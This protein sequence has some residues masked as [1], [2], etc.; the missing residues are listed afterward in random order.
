MVRRG[1]VS[2]SN[3]HGTTSQPLSWAVWQLGE[4]C[5]H[6]LPTR[7]AVLP[8]LGTTSGMTRPARTPSGGNQDL[9][10]L[11]TGAERRE[12]KLTRQQPP[13]VSS[14]SGSTGGGV[15]GVLL[16]GGTGW[17]VCRCPQA[18]RLWAPR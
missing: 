12:E 18:L 11:D 6:Q 13:S 3:K 4:P 7:T 16:D 14:V 1:F 8:G 9:K 5:A 15:G 10:C 17:M 2:S